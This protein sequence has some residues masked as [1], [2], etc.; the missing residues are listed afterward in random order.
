MFTFSFFFLTPIKV[1]RVVC[2]DLGWSKNPLFMT[3]TCIN[4]V[5]IL[6]HIH[7]VS[8][9]ILISVF[10]LFNIILFDLCPLQE[11]AV[12]QSWSEKWLPTLIS[13]FQVSCYRR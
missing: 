11:A 10:I 2:A 5:K 12:T 7:H 9:L 4:C 3:C 6:N 13:G 1:A 8:W